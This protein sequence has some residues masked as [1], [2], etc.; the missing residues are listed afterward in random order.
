MLNDADRLHGQIPPEY[1]ERLVEAEARSAREL[2][3]FNME[4]PMRRPDGQVRWMQ[5]HSRPRRMPDGRIIWDGV[6]TDITER[7][8]AEEAL[9][10]LK[11]ELEERSRSARRHWRKP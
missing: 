6:Q 3:D 4:V 8:R 10:R 9:R 5:L 2:S 7:K 1:F 11:E